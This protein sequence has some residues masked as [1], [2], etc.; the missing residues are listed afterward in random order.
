M[1]RGH[2][3]KLQDLSS[4]I[5]KLRRAGTAPTFNQGQVNILVGKLRR[6]MDGEVTKTKKTETKRSKSQELGEILRRV[7]SGSTTADP[8]IQEAVRLLREAARDKMM[9]GDAVMVAKRACRLMQQQ[10]KSQVEMENYIKDKLVMPILDKVFKAFLVVLE[11]TNVHL[12]EDVKNYVET[13]IKG[14]KSR[15]EFIHML[16]SG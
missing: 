15:K 8:A 13:C 10:K 12:D 9:S 11:T 14:A 2:R 7:Q 4:G 6:W 5:A 16:L 1:L 3:K